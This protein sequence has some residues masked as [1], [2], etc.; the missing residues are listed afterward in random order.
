MNFHSLD[1]F[2]TMTE[3]ER[4]YTLF[5]WGQDNL[6]SL[7]GKDLERACADLTNYFLHHP[8]LSI[9][10]NG[11]V[12]KHYWGNDTVLNHHHLSYSI[13]ELILNILVYKKCEY[14]SIIPARKPFYLSKLLRDDSHPL[15]QPTPVLPNESLDE[16]ND[17]LTTELEATILDKIEVTPSMVPTDFPSDTTQPIDSDKQKTRDI[18][19]ISNPSDDVVVDTIQSGQKLYQVEYIPGKLSLYW[20]FDSKLPRFINKDI[21][22]KKN[23]LDKII[24]VSGYSLKQKDIIWAGVSIG[25]LDVPEYKPAE[26]KSSKKEKTKS[27]DL[28]DNDKPEETTTKK[29]LKNK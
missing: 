20:D 8:E 16:N 2:F 23:N 1:N 10:T 17:S 22:D 27:S 15:P 29:K 24:K 19:Y 4:N 5:Q 28:G 9:V 13:K 12:D 7:Q 21:K 14:I 18:S 11:I 26:K 25:Y 3:K 6:L